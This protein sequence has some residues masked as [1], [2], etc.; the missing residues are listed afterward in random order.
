[1]T[2]HRCDFTTARHYLMDTRDQ[3]RRLHESVSRLVWSLLHVALSHCPA[4]REPSQPDIF[5]N[6]NQTNVS[7]FL[8]AHGC[9]SGSTPRRTPRPRPH[10]SHRSLR[11]SSSSPLD[12]QGR[13]GH[14]PVCVCNS[15]GVRLPFAAGIQVLVAETYSKAKGELP[16]A[17]IQLV[18][19]PVVRKLGVIYRPRADYRSL[20]LPS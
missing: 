14:M 20:L 1:M 6:P 15:T 7:T 5:S 8:C 11:E 12:R 9:P 10:R 18:T 17:N 2:R 19:L 13:T 4:P 16:L 3:R